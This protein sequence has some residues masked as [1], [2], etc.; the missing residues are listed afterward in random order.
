MRSSPLGLFP[1]SQAPIGDTLAA[2]RSS[3]GAAAGAAVLLALIEKSPPHQAPPAA[4]GA[5]LDLNAVDREVLRFK[6]TVMASSYSCK[7]AA[8]PLVARSRASAARVAPRVA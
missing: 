4:L 5:A 3:D 1:A 6:D 8:T 2:V 7:A